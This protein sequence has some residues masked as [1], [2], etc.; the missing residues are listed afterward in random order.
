M[1]VEICMKVSLN[2]SDLISYDLKFQTNAQGFLNIVTDI[3]LHINQLSLDQSFYEL[4]NEDKGLY[5][6]GLESTVYGQLPQ[7]RTLMV[8]LLYQRHMAKTKKLFSSWEGFTILFKSS[9][10]IIKS[11]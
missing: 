7:V 6:P 9:H 3:T 5:C 1:L 2:F 4:S 11:H 10:S 8:A